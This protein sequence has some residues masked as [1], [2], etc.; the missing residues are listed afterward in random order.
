MRVVSSEHLKRQREG[1]AEVASHAR[2]FSMDAIVV[3]GARR[4]YSKSRLPVIYVRGPDDLEPAWFVCCATVG[5]FAAP[6]AGRR[7][8]DEVRRRLE[9]MA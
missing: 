7:A 9:S 6:R 4:W 5:L 1:E 8:F 3:V 2:R